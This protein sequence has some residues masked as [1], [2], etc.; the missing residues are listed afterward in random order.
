MDKTVLKFGNVEIE[1]QKFH[2]HKGPI[3]I[4]NIGTNKIVVSKEV[5]FCKKGFKY[6]IGYK[7]AKNVRHLCIFL[8]K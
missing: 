6:F 5:S 8:P 4:N 1:K 7:D 2:Q 3:W